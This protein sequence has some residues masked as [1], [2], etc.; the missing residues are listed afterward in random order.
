MDF[1]FET[2]LALPP[3]PVFAFHASAARLELLHQDWPR[4][5][6]LA[7]EPHVRVGGETWIEISLSSHVPMALGFRH[8]HFKSPSYFGERLIHGPFSCF[9]HDH[10]F[11]RVPEGTLVRDLLKVQLPWHYGGETTVRRAVAP[12]LIRMFRERGTALRRTARERCK[13]NS[14]P[15]LRTPSP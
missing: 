2:I 9:V 8:T 3:E 4:V 15:A 14:S 5:R 1:R 7:Y 11:E 12:C 13:N 10:E 6:L